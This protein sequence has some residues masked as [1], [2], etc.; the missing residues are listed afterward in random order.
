MVKINFKI[1]ENRVPILSKNEIESIARVI[2]SDYDS[3]I[4][5]KPK[6]LDVEDFAENYLSLDMDYQDLSHDQPILGMMVFNECWITVY[7]AEN[8][9]KRYV[10]AKEGTI[11]IDNSLLNDEQLRRGRFTLG[12][13]IGHWVLHKSKYS[14]NPN[15]LTFFDK[16]P[17]QLK[18]I[19]KC[20][21]HNIESYKRKLISIGL[22]GKQ[23][24]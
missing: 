20:R 10:E 16:S 19:T 3:Q 24:I 17:E 11:F 12:H 7:D 14:F 1:G 9:G 23:I 4:L 22:S 5:E 18:P 6:I 13:E 8:N 21:K 2:L 15:Q